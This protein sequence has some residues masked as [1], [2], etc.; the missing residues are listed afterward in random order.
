MLIERQ[1]LV[2]RPELAIREPANRS[3]LQYTRSTREIV[4]FFNFCRDVR[5]NHSGEAAPSTPP[6]FTSTEAVTETACRYKSDLQI[7]RQTC[8]Y[9]YRPQSR[10]VLARQYWLPRPSLPGAHLV[11]PAVPA[12]VLVHP[13]AFLNGSLDLHVNCKAGYVTAVCACNCGIQS[14][15]A[16]T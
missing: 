2:A 7:H 10:A 3:Q 15:T 14:V 16:R 1:S 4:F 6:V 11:H 5:I 12:T 8:S 9:R 13:A